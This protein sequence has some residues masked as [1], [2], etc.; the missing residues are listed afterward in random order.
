VSWRTYLPHRMRSS[1]SYTVK[2]WQVFGGR[3]W[4]LV[5]FPQV[6]TVSPANDADIAS[7]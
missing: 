5:L 7:K 3:R 6:L 2:G 4:S 1:R